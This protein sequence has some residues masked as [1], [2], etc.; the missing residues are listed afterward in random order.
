MHALIIELKYIYVYI[1]YSELFIRKKQILGSTSLKKLFRAQV[2][3]H[4]AAKAEP[5][6]APID[7]LCD[8]NVSFDM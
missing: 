4:S 5:E 6:V 7:I 8:K 3:S 1:L 2:M